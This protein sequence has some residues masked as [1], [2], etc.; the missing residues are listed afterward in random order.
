M[1]RKRRKSDLLNISDVV[2]LEADPVKRAAL[3]HATAVAAGRASP[4]VIYEADQILLE[5]GKPPS[6]EDAEAHGVLILLAEDNLT[7][8]DV[9]RRQLHLLGYAVDVMDDGKLAQEALHRKSY[10]LLL[11]DCHMPNMDGFE[12]TE[13]IRQEEHETRKRL[14]VIA[15]TAAALKEEVARCFDVGMDDFISKPVDMGK[16]RDALRKWMPVSQHMAEPETLSVEPTAPLQANEDTHGP[17]DPRALMDVF[18]DDA[19]TFREILQEFV[20]PASDNIRE[21]E[22][23]FAARSADGVA[24]AAH[25]LKSSSRA[26]GANELADLCLALEMAGKGEDWSV[27]DNDAPRLGNVMQAVSAYVGTL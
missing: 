19:E 9:I 3:I 7:N 2:Y 26:V 5:K 10:A 11:T 4:D 21:I 16:L 20:E 12:L 14:P 23:A 15:I 6:V 17:I 24:K 18:G 8:Q 27:I 22:D 13:A 1:T 25:K